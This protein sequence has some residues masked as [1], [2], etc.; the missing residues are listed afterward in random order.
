MMTSLKFENFRG[1]TD[2]AVSSLKRINL[3][4]GSNNT[5]KTGIL[6]GLYLLFATDL[7]Q[8]LR[9]PSVFRSNVSGQAG[10]PSNDDFPVFWQSLFYDKQPATL[11]SVSGRH[12]SGAASALQLST[13]ANG[14]IQILYEGLGGGPGGP[15]QPTI[16]TTGQ[17]PRGGPPRTLSKYM[18]AEAD[19]PGRI[20]SQLRSSFSR[21][22][23]SN[24]PG[25]PTFTTK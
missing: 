7:N 6:E 24:R 19:R 1:F 9:L 23:W 14:T 21:P 10:Q 12:D 15:S 2:L 20:H 8:V 5:G 17:H 4:A 13:S 22:G 16:R 25:M 18:P 3:I 11:A